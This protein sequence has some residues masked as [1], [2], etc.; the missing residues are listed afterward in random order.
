MSQNKY[1]SLEVRLKEYP[2]P[3]SYKRT[4]NTKIEPS[5]GYM[6]FYDRWHPL[7]GLSGKVLLHRH[8]MSKRLGRWITTGEYVHH[9]DHNKTNNSHENLEVLTA[10]QHN[11]KHAIERGQKITTEIECKY[12]RKVF[13]QKDTRNKHCSVDCAKYSSRKVQRP[14]KETLERLVWEKPTRQLAITLEVSDKSIEKWC[15]TYGIKKPGPGYWRQ[16]EVLN[17]KKT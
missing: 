5:T 2:D 17:N 10:I 14:D 9:V 16:I 8:E 6:Y 7:A 15:R 4:L 1:K 3:K 11:Q 12:C 13:K